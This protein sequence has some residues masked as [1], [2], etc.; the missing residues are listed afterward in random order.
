MGYTSIAGTGARLVQ[1]LSPRLRT[2]VLEAYGLKCLSYRLL[3]TRAPLVGEWWHGTLQLSKQQRSGGC[4]CCRV[5]VWV[6]GCLCPQHLTF[7]RY[8]IISVH[9]DRAVLYGYVDVP[10]D[11]E[12]K[13]PLPDWHM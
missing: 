12:F 10:V 1:D 6:Q 4:F 9:E 3:F 8:G 11:E 7:L 2:A 13:A 5:R